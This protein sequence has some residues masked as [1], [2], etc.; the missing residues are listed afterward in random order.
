L[1]VTPSVPNRGAPLFINPNRR[2]SRG[3][4]S[5]DA[6]GVQDRLGLKDLQSRWADDAALDNRRRRDGSLSVNVILSIPAGTDAAA[7]KDAARAFAI[8]TFEGEIADHP[9]PRASTFVR[10]RSRWRNRD[11]PTSIAPAISIPAFAW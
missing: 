10:Y 7:V 6:F 2:P 8:E 5:F 3:K 9:A 11:A 4:R 1:S